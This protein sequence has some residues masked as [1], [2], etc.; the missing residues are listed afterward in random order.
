MLRFLLLALA[1]PLAVRAQ[2]PCPSTCAAFV[3]PADLS[4]F[5]QSTAFTAAV[6]VDDAAQNANRRTD[7]AARMA[8]CVGG[9]LRGVVQAQQ[10]EG[11]SFYFL[12]VAG[13][14]NERDAPISLY[15][16]SAQDGDIVAPLA[17]ASNADNTPTFEAGTSYGSTT[18]PYRTQARSQDLPVEL[19]AFDAVADGAGALLR[20]S[21][22]S[23]TNNSGFWVDH[24]APDASLFA[25]REFVAG[26]GTTLEAQS[27]ALSITDLAP[28]EHRFRL[29]QTDLDGSETLSAEVRLSVELLTEYRLTTVRPNPVRGISR[30]KV[31]VRKS[32]KV[33]VV[34]YDALGRRVATLFSGVLDASR[35]QTVVV[36]ASHLSAGLY[37]VR[38]EGE[39][40]SVARMLTVVR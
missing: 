25:G 17:P 6:Y 20:W 32:Q 28:G 2:T 38:L 18:I 4:R 8:G 26:A 30:L 24:Q 40:L 22:A 7:G 10:V 33:D 34:L 21:T 16:C 3:A 35:D 1:F 23:E 37:A 5:T 14:P 11:E 39:M 19:I 29:R 12:S 9:E 13:E 31:A 27:Y 15:Y 36:D